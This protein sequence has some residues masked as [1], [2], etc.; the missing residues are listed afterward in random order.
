MEAA[1]KAPQFAEKAFFEYHIYDLQR[2]TTVKDK[3][4]KQ[5]SLLEASDAKVGKEL[6]SYGIQ[7]YFTAEFRDR[8]PK[9]PVGVYVS[10]KN[11]KDNSLGMP[12]PGGIMRL[13]KKDDSGSSQFIGEDKIE[14]TPKDEK[15]K[16]K[17]GEAFDVVVERRQTDFK[18]LTAHLFE[19][20]WE[21]VVRNH[22]DKEVTVGLVEPLFGSWQVMNN[23]HP[24]TKLD[25]HTIRFDVA[26]PKDGEAKVKYRV[27]VGF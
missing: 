3:Q 9:Q 14:H 18:R 17:I 6:L 20:E 24:Y 1:P 12:L 25:A 16:L 27:R 23:S 15:L 10:F 13:Y 2:K 8:N 26:V 4:T 7:S 5:V 21:V 19:S 22:K 11:S